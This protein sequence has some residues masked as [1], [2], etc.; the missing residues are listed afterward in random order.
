MSFFALKLSNREFE[1]TV[2]KILR[3]AKY[4][5]VKGL[6][7]LDSEL[8]NGSFVF[9]Q[10]GGQNDVFWDKG[11][12]GLAQIVKEPFKRGYDTEHPRNFLIGL[13]MIILLNGV[14]KR[15]EFV[16]Y[17]NAYDAGGIGP[18][19]RG[20][21][22]QAIKAISDVQ[23]YTIMRV[24]VDKQHELEEPIKI[25]VNHDPEKCDL[26]FGRIPLLFERYV[27]Y[28]ESLNAEKTSLT[29]YQEMTLDERRVA[30][31]EWMKKQYKSNG[32][33]YKES[34]AY[35]YSNS[36]ANNASYLTGF[37]GE[38]TNLFYYTDAGDFV[39]VME[40]IRGLENFDTI[41]DS[42]NG[43]FSASMKKYCTFLINLS[44]P[45]SEDEIDEENEDTQEG[46][47]IERKPREK[48]IYPF[49]FIIYGAPGTGKTYST[50]RYAVEIMNGKKFDDDID[51]DEIFKQYKQYWND[52]RVMFTT[53]HQNYGYEEFIQG[54]RPDPEADNLSFKPVDGYF[55]KL[56]DKALNDPDNDYV[57]IIDE[58]NRANI[59]KVFGELITLIE[60]DKRW[61]EKHEMCV[62][63]PSGDVFRVPNN[64]FIIGTMNSADKSISLIDAALRRRFDFFEQK[65]E[66]EL[67]ND[68]E[69]RA[70]FVKLNEYLEEKLKSSDLLIGHSY[71][72]NKDINS[73][74]EILNNKVIPLLYEYFYD[75]R[76]KV[77]AA[78]QEALRDYK[79]R[80]TIKTE[81][82]GRLRVEEI[83]N[84]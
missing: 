55:K 5:V 28:S 73:L 42:A 26:I 8:S 69:L 32:K 22:D 23:A 25:A 31:Y 65:P 33:P 51:H 78:L 53:F 68:L 56:A 52:G 48:R 36:L 67:I 1:K 80:F 50:P 19:T 83:I 15:S 16:P 44:V 11:L 2:R 39:A 13:K 3:G 47:E 46:E 17:V 38:N 41:N 4:I 10:L 75:Q 7:Q 27:S 70:I 59:S 62:T 14:I 76:E 81:H 54:L 58:I 34:T 9:V 29:Q 6:N 66:S 35:N 57:I 12:I 18:N 37:E 30:F 60:D 20:Q 24:M 21:Q 72:M 79:S 40:Q 43:T 61:G 71:F 49:N 74:P 64:L 63:L 77:L 45:D 82:F 84:V